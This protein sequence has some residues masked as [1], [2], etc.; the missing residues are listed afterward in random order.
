[1]T[2]NP[3]GDLRAEYD[4]RMLAEAFYES[5][6]FRSILESKDKSIIVGRRGTGKSAIFLQL[7]RQ[8]AADENTTVVPLAPDEADIIALRPALKR[9]GP[10]PSHLRVASK[11]VCQYTILTWILR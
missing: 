2:G 10:K 4:R 7:T 1:M 8:F 3:L 5:P 6:D 9:F 11:I